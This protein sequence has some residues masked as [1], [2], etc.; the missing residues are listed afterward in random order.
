MMAGSHVLLGGAAWLVAAP[1]LGL[2]ALDPVLLGLA[3]GGSLLPDADHPGSWVGRRLRPMSGVLARLGGH[4]GATHSLLAVAGCVALLR[5]GAM[6]IWFVAPLVVG[7]LSHLAADLLTRGGLRLAWPA[8]GVVAV[9]LCRTGGA[10]EPVVVMCVV[11]AV[12]WGQGAPR[13]LAGVGSAHP[14]FLRMSHPNDRPRVP[15][16]H[17]K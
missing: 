16:D 14:P 3:L 11:A 8:P 10:M 7:Y 13:P 1:H 4:R 12:L 17:G 6:P 2:P 15:L 5:S 9:P